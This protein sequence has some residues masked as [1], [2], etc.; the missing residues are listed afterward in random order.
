MNKYLRYWSGT[1]ML[2]L[3]TVSQALSE[4]KE[5]TKPM[6][7]KNFTVSAYGLH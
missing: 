4:I 3:F 5:T 2:I 1:K 6:T 7:L